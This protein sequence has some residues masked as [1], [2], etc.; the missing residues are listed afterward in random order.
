MSKDN[1]PAIVYRDPPPTLVLS[2]EQGGVAVDAVPEISRLTAEMLKAEA[3]DFDDPSADLYCVY[4][5]QN[6]TQHGTAPAPCGSIYTAITK[7]TQNM[8]TLINGCGS[9]HDHTEK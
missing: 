3:T 8:L 5:E 7:V 1:T 2:C 6:L 9:R 4:T